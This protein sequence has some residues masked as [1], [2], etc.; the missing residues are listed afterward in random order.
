MREA[1]E[2]LLGGVGKLESLVGVNWGVNAEWVSR[3]VAT[4]VDTQFAEL[5]VGVLSLKTSVVDWDA[6]IEASVRRL[7]PFDKGDKEK[8]FRDAIVCETFMQLVQTLP[9]G[10]REQAVLVTADTLLTEAVKARL[11]GVS[12]AKI[13]SDLDGLRGTLNIMLSQVPPEFAQELIAKANAMF[14]VPS[15]TDTMYYTHKVDETIK[16][17]FP[18]TFSALPEGASNIA[19]LGSMMHHTNFERKEGQRVYFVNRLIYELKA[20]RLEVSAGDSQQVNLNPLAQIKNSLLGS[21]RNVETVA[22]RTAIFDIHWS[23]TLSQT[24]KLQRENIDDYRLASV[25]ETL[26]LPGGGQ[27]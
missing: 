27:I 12:N 4:A 9:S 2:K 21:M 13:V 19:V 25:N 5:K 26:V 20:T 15:Q 1:A 22:T 16:I 18:E 23:A 7:A 14:Y 6:L 11:H 8:G 24:K 3:A 10:S 17:R